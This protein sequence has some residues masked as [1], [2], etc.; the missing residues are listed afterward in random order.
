MDPQGSPSASQSRNRL[1]SS[2]SAR[3]A[4]IPSRQV[5]PASSS[6]SVAFPHNHAI[7]AL[8]SNQAYVPSSRTWTPSSGG[9]GLFSDSDEVQDRAVFVEEYNR[10]AK[11]HGVR[12]L[13]VGDFGCGAQRRSNGTP[14][15][16]RHGW[17][18][19]IFR[20][21]S[22]QSTPTKA[23]AA[24]RTL[25]RRS[26][27]DLGYLIRSRPET[28]KT[29]GIQ[30]MV[31][32]SGK[33]A[34]YLPPEYSPCSLIL[35]TCVRATA[36]YIAQN[37]TTRGIFRIPGS[38]KVVNSLYD[39]YCYT[40]NNGPAVSG[41]VCRATLP[42]HIPYS[43]HDV[44]STFKR[45]LSALPG[46]I[47]GSLT[48]FDAF[49]GIHSQLQGQP[50]FPRTKQTKIRAR[51][52]ALAI[53]TIESQFRR[54]LICAVFG[55]L[56]LIGRI[57]EVSPHEDCDGR[58]LP[59]NDLMGYSALGIVFGPL[60]V[61]DLL[62]RYAMKLATPTSGLLLFPMSPRKQ[63]RDR[64]RAKMAK[65]LQPAFLEVDKVMVAIN[66]AEMLIA[67][68]RDVVRQMKA[69]GT[70]VHHDT[71]SMRFKRGDVHSSTSE[72][73]V[74]SAP[75]DSDVFAMGDGDTG[76]VAV[77]RDCSPEP[78]APSKAL[79][80]GRS[81]LLRQTSGKGLSGQPPPCS[82]LSQAVEE[83]E[84]LEKARSSSNIFLAASAGSK[85]R[86]AA[87]DDD[88]G[89][90]P[91][92]RPL[93]LQDN[94]RVVGARRNGSIPL[95]HSCSC[96]EVSWLSAENAPA[97]GLAQSISMNIIPPRVS[98]RHTKHVSISTTAPNF[99][100]DTGNTCINQ[101]TTPEG[102]FVRVSKGA[103]GHEEME[104]QATGAV[105][106]AARSPLSDR[107]HEKRRAFESLLTRS[108]EKL[109]GTQPNVCYAPPPEL[110]V[111]G[112]VAK[113]S[114]HCHLHPPI[115][116][117]ESASDLIK[118]TQPAKAKQCTEA[119]GAS[120][121]RQSTNA[122]SNHGGPFE[123]GQGSNN[124]AR[125]PDLISIGSDTSQEG[126]NSKQSLG[127]K[128][129]TKR[130]SVRALAAMF[131]GQHDPLSTRRKPWT[132]A[133]S[134]A[135]NLTQGTDQDKSMPCRIHSSPQKSLQLAKALHSHPEAVENT[136]LKDVEDG[137]YSPSSNTWPLVTTQRDDGRDSCGGSSSSS[138]S[139]SSSSSSSSGSSGSGSRQRAPPAEVCEK[140]TQTIAGDDQAASSLK[141]YDCRDTSTMTDGTGMEDVHSRLH[142]LER[143]LG[144]KSEEAAQLKLRVQQLEEEHDEASL[145]DRVLS[146]AGRE[147]RKW[148]ERAEA[149]ER[150]AKMF[151]KFT[152]RV[153]S[154]HGAVAAE[155]S[156]HGGDDLRGGGLASEQGRDAGGSYRV[157]RVRFA[158]GNEAA[159]GGVVV[160]RDDDCGMPEG[161][162]SPSVSDGAP[163][164]LCGGMDGVASP[165]EDGKLDFG[166]AAAELWIAAQELLLLMDDED[167]DE[168]AAAASQRL[169][170]SSADEI[171]AEAGDE[172]DWHV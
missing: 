7:Q 69:L 144:V 120:E 96:Q 63:R 28:S 22:N 137:K 103:K 100:T 13:V 118:A 43:V 58:P 169:S 145:R 162:P 74:A 71:A 40:G 46:G 112:N 42:T 138:S 80:R 65:D 135:A 57:A 35:P 4:S 105:H 130:G 158:M 81:R 36:Q 167:D 32:L 50:E 124:E 21:T 10:L 164:A 86:L 108:A 89:N 102:S 48:L 110:W 99:E 2:Q 12:L 119:N 38:V 90:A 161:G 165:R 45:F 170:G 8:L 9:L 11:K 49:I 51:L 23:A 16:E 30:D 155:G 114:L 171:C 41:T 77:D 148:R 64:Q 19:R 125:L 127:G 93:L 133:S 109:R 1:P 142:E 53:G 34:L 79:R 94:D 131:E 136:E 76:D 123:P 59:T 73:L 18:Y 31:R 159:D 84:N 55:L 163:R 75:V 172:E 27:S 91:D 66:I 121:P 61:G 139:N 113:E 126:N 87:L 141:R 78:E 116:A 106:C 101:M 52:I 140:G 153:R 62:D 147:V 44:G 68:W 98:S 129:P 122:A 60:L 24:S 132:G 166:L 5:R 14:S 20:G 92:L 56:S 115:Y 82:H 37:A 29:I 160:A 150:R 157:H 72:S 39:Y 146:D 70:H 85:A 154:I 97:A 134:D 67:N 104:A 15:P 156:R 151:Q 95:M 168:A 111:P 47:L 152:A 107:L 3:Q 149:A 88:G 54:E 26:V 25:H 143:L 17:L 6:A 33:S 83:G 117:C 128:T